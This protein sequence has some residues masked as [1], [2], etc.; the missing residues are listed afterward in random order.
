MN[1]VFVNVNE[2]AFA[3]EIP[4]GQGNTNFNSVGVGT[5]SKV[6]RAD[7]SG[8]WLGAAEFASAPFR[9]DMQGNATLNSVTVSGYVE[10][11]AGTYTSASS[12][13]RVQLLPDFNTGILAYN[14]SNA[15][16]F[17]VLVGGT[18]SGDVTLGNYGGGTGMFWDN[19]ASTFTIKG[20]MTAGTITGVTFQTASSGS[21]VVISAGGSKIEIKDS[22]G[23]NLLELDD[24]V[25]IFAGRSSTPSE[26]N[27]I[28][29]YKSGANY[30]FRTRM[31]SG[32]WQITQSAV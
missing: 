29:Y 17:E 25:I 30:G 11:V 8:I 21:R 13:A 10:D 31:E 14:S 7:P 3:V 9:V 16:V 26:V 27:A 28:W 32:N 12:G 18:N 23:N 4:L 22:G 6:F 19:S 24:E 1:D 20:D 2:K 15:K 5:G